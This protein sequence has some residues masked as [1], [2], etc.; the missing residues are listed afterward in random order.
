MGAAKQLLPVDGVP[1]LLKIAAELRQSTVDDVF[2]VTHSEIASHLPGESVI[3]NDDPAS[4]MIDSI[5]LGLAAH[6]GSADGFLICL[7]DQ[8]GISSE[9]IDR[10][11]EAF[12]ASPQ[13][14][15][16][17]THAG[18]RGHPMIFPA[19]LA[20]QVSSPLCDEGLNALPREHPQLIREIEC[21]PPAVQNVNTPEDYRQ[22]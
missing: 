21:G 6:R 11:V 19:F 17:A 10:C 18:R 5:R 8:P 7:G 22:L 12:R 3:I 16:I 13:T 1:M 9:D 20:D 15:V 4:E 14:M 2:V